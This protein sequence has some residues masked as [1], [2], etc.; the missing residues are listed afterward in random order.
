[1][2]ASFLS[3]VASSI[4]MKRHFLWAIRKSVRAV[5]LAHREP[6]KGKRGFTIC[7]MLEG[8]LIHAWGGSKGGGAKGTLIN[9]WGGSGCSSE[10]IHLIL[11]LQKYSIPF[12]TKLSVLPLGKGNRRSE[13]DHFTLRFIKIKVNP[14]SPQSQRMSL[15]LSRSNLVLNEVPVPYSFSWIPAKTRLHLL[16][17]RSSPVESCFRLS[18]SLSRIPRDPL[19]YFV[20]VIAS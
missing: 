18:I 10:L 3:K 15:V 20:W 1:M 17:E 4:P 7:A 19:F 12:L 11:R 13:S 5:P 9:A 14:A 16:S 2:Q 6:W 8:S